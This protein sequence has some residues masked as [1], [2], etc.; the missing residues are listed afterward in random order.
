MENLTLACWIVFSALILIPVAW[1]LGWFG[2]IDE[3]TYNES[4]RKK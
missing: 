1:E 4:Q 3:I 2:G